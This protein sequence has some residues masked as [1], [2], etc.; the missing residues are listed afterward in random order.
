MPFSSFLTPFRLVDL[1]WQ[2]AIIA[3]YIKISTLS[4]YVKTGK[5]C[6][7]V[8]SCLIQSEQ[9]REPMTEAQTK[10]VRAVLIYVGECPVCRKTVLKPFS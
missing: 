4:A 8:V 10:A 9:E 2:T 5:K 3:A 1:D 6:C 7:S